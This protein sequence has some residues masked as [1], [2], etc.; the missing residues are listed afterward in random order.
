[1]TLLRAG[2]ILAWNTVQESLRSRYYLLCLVFGA[3]LIYVSLLLGLL[4]ADQEVRVLLDFGLAL[5]ELLGLAVAVYG[6]ATTILREIET[7]TIY[8]IMTRPISRGAYLLG[9]FAGLML[10]TAAVMAAMA[11]V[12]VS[13]LLLKGWSWSAAYPTALAGSYLKLLVAAALTL[14]LA[15]F[16][17]S[18]LA[19]LVLALILWTLGHVLPEIRNLI[20][21]GAHPALTA[22]LV[23]LSYLV[24]DLQMLNVRDRLAAPGALLMPL[25]Y[26]TLYCGVWLALAAAR[27]RRKEF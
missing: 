2:A 15:L 20:K 7:K 4:A 12:H 17:S 9:R 18:V 23:V 6:A 13:L 24:P 5:I 16:S 22:P 27:L 11:C 8:L 14:F 25:G 10:S 3:A 26:A 21:L 1:M 19:A